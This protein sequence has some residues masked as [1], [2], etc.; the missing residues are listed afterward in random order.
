M[1]VSRARRDTSQRQRRGSLFD[2]FSDDVFSDPYFGERQ[3]MH[4]RAEAVE[5][6][7]KPLPAAGRPPEFSGAVGQFTFSAEGSPRQVKVGD[8]VTMKLT[9]SGRGNFD[10]VEAPA[11]SESS[12]WR[13]YPPSANFHSEDEISIRGTKTFELAVIPETKKTAMPVFAFAYFDPEQE[14]Y[15]TLRSEPAALTV[16]GGAPPPPPAIVQPGATADEPPRAA[17]AAAE[18]CDILGI[19]YDAP[20]RRASFRPLYLRRYFLLAQAVPLARG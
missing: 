10:R 2:L 6:D 20:A 9:V 7:V 16:E 12:G 13:V 5:I 18:Q 15:V 4:A 1:R 11:L 17:S 19:R 8:P 14:K 3:Q